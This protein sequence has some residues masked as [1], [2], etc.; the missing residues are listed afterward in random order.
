VIGAFLQPLGIMGGF[1]P[2]GALRKVEGS[3]PS[4]VLV[5]LAFA[6]TGDFQEP[7]LRGEYLF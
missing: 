5:L 7:L 6:W 4:M 3:F 2:F 1:L